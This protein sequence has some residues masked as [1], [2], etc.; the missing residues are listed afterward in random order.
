MHDTLEDWRDVRS[1][2]IP[3]KRL[4]NASLCRCS[5]FDCVKVKWNCGRSRFGIGSTISSAMLFRECVLVKV[6][7]NEDAS[8]TRLDKTGLLDDVIAW[9]ISFVRPFRFF[10]SYDH[11]TQL[12]HNFPKFQWSQLSESIKSCFVLLLKSHSRENGN[13]IQSENTNTNVPVRSITLWN[14]TVWIPPDSGC[15]PLTHYHFSNSFREMQKPWPIL[16]LNMHGSLICSGSAY[17]SL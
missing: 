3:S 12:D 11:L 2:S 1:F 13:F 9:F 7:L 16:R 17:L 8:L 14:I 5:R 4:F 15:V 10:S 6:G